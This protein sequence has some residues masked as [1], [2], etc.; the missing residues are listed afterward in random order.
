LKEK[1]DLTIKENWN[2]SNAEEIALQLGFVCDDTF[3]VILEK[4]I[5][6]TVVTAILTNY[7]AVLAMGFFNRAGADPEICPI[8]PR[9]SSRLNT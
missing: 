4:Y 6:E 5:E 7:L 2:C 8:R 3:S 9:S 1:L